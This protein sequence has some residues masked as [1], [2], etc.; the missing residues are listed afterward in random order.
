MENRKPNRAEIL[1]SSIN[2][3]YSVL[4]IS[5]KH[6][7]RGRRDPRIVL[8]HGQTARDGL[9]QLKYLK[10]KTGKDYRAAVVVSKKISKKAPVRNRIRRRIYEII[11]T[12][13][14]P[15]GIDFIILV[16]EESAATIEYE[17]LRNS[18]EN[19][20]SKITI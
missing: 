8:K 16:H 17:T 2:H 9:L 20:V 12:I 19:L 18:V 5:S 3:L 7:F 4:M 15:E 11:R 14:I 6:R 1:A 10:N 13:D